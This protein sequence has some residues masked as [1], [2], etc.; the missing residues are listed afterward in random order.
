MGRI[1]EEITPAS[2]PN[3][4]GWVSKN[5]PGRSHLAAQGRHKLFPRKA[6]WLFWGLLGLLG[7]AW[8]FWGL[9]GASGTLWGL[10]GP[11]GAF[12]GLSVSLKPQQVPEGPKRPRKSPE[13]PRRPQKARESPR[14]PQKPPEA[15]RK[16]K[17][18][19]EGLGMAQG[20][21]FPKIIA[22]IFPFKKRPFPY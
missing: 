3:I 20:S 18:A 9:L 12:W 10:L 15:P 11:P 7:L 22:F 5:I 17:Q 4:N 19:P 16:P 2:T 14:T 13:G 1:S 8:A 21:N 6:F